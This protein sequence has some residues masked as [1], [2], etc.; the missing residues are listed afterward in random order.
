MNRRSTSAISPQSQRAQQQLR[1]RRMQE[2]AAANPNGAS[3]IRQGQKQQEYIDPGMQQNQAAHNQDGHYVQRVRAKQQQQRAQAQ[4]AA[5]QRAQQQARRAQQMHMPGDGDDEI[6]QAQAYF[7]QL[8]ASQ[9]RRRPNSGSSFFKKLIN[10]SVIVAIAYAGYWLHQHHLLDGVY[11]KFRSNDDFVANTGESNASINSN[12]SEADLEV[13]ANQ[14][15]QTKSTSADMVDQYLKKWNK[16]SKAEKR[17]VMD[18]VWYQHFS[19]VVESRIR[20]YQRRVAFGTKHTSGAE[21][22]KLQHAS[23]PLMKIAT[24]V[25]IV[26]KPLEDSLSSK[27]ER[28]KQMMAEVE[29][30]IREQRTEKEQ[31]RNDLLQTS[32]LESKS[33]SAS[34]FQ[35]PAPSTTSKNSQQT[36]TAKTNDSVKKV[37]KSTAAIQIQHIVTQRDI[38][39]VLSEYKLAYQKGDV[40]ALLALFQGEKTLNESQRIGLLRENYETSFKL[41][42][43]RQIKLADLKWEQQG[44]QLFGSGNYKETFKL[45]N[46]KDTREISAKLNLELRSRPGQQEGAYIA[47]FN[48]T[49][50]TVTQLKPE[51]SVASKSVKELPNHKKPVAPTAAEL[52]DLVAKFI[53]VWESGNSKDLTALLSKDAKTNDKTNRDAIVKEYSNIFQATYDREMYI[54]NMQWETSG[55]FAKGRGFLEAMSFSKEDDDIKNVTGKI[56][57]VAHR[58]GNQVKI[59]HLYHLTQDQ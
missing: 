13:I 43:Q 53:R 18:T 30:D 36:S 20:D 57:I 52:Q 16:L 47:N 3:A 27:Q 19:F 21:M 10:L 31:Q 7:E 54:S 51:I 8:Q 41:S 26:K 15:I 14:I 17:Q 1:Q 5:Q 23:I 6:A 35:K 2:N 56:Q 55:S 38:D 25:G 59:T 44:N 12:V 28:F 24:A 37:G 46:G 50:Q 40:D 4:R 49:D 39:D 9:S 33:L 45:G 58:E 48:L 42:K 11:A 29:K 34:S 22:E 32:K